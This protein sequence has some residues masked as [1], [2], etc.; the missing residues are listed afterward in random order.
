M[1]PEGLEM[2]S[3]LVRAHAILG[4]VRMSES[5]GSAKGRT[6]LVTAMRGVSAT[7]GMAALLLNAACS[8]N[9][10]INPAYNN[11][12]YTNPQPS[13]NAI[14]T[15]I[16]AG[17]GGYVGNQIGKGPAAKTAATV[18]GVIIGAI[19]GDALT[20]PQPQMQV[21]PAYQGQPY[22]YQGYQ[23]QAYQ[24]QG[25]QGG[26]YQSQGY[27]G[28]TDSQYM[29]AAESAA[30]SAPIGATQR[31]QNPATGNGGSVTPIRDGN[32]NGRPCRQFQAAM[33]LNGTRTS[34]VVTSCQSY[35]GSWQVLGAAD[36]GQGR[37]LADAAES[38]DSGR[39]PG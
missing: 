27:G 5:T 23:G 14:G 35:D 36:V 38:R 1:A 15:L 12:A 26:G 25:Y 20:R 2:S 32:Y 31:W 19:L 34:G 3:L 6:R 24:G 4:N 9:Q 39:R 30:Y 17:A 8:V 7:G 21:A 10:G 13:G 22:Q 11:P 29:Q 16:G 37:F 33:H 18:G 28:M